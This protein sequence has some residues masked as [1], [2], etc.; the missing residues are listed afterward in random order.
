MFSGVFG[1][2]GGSLFLRCFIC[3]LAVEV[4]TLAFIQGT[5]HRNIPFSLK[6][7]YPALEESVT[8]AL[9][10]M[11]DFFHHILKWVILFFFE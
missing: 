11:E 1:E 2:R 4:K 6:Y 3:G 5:E 10:L 9:W 8:S 7:W